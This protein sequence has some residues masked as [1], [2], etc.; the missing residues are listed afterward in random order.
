MASIRNLKKDINYL[1]TEVISECYFKKLLI[2]SLEDDA[3]TD[4]IKQTVALRNDM[5]ARANHTD[6]KQNPKLVKQY[7]RNLRKDLLAC[8]SELGNL[9]S[10]SR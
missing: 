9:I 7:Y 6:A 2:N 10:K 5:I 4:I 3:L 1:A 8:F